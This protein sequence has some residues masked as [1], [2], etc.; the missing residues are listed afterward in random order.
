MLKIYNYVNI[1]NS[2]KKKLKLNKHFIV[3]VHFSTHF[4]QVPFW[5]KYQFLEATKFENVLSI[6]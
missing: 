2:K 4:Q 3:S 1:Y 5:K 6:S